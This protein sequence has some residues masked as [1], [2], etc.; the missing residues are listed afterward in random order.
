M[1]SADIKC[2]LIELP[3]HSVMRNMARPQRPTIIFHTLADWLKQNIITQVLNT[4]IGSDQ[5]G[6]PQAQSSVHVDY[7]KERNDAFTPIV[8][9]SIIEVRREVL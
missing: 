8:S 9:H 3:N 7:G 4:Q 2:N 1:C 5:V 6:Q